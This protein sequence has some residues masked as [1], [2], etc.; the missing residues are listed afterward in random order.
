M[1]TPAY[2][3]HETAQKCLQYPRASNPFFKPNHGP[4]GLLKA[5]A[6]FTQSFNRI[7]STKN[8]GN[9]TQLKFMYSKSIKL[10]T[11]LRF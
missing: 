6:A 11:F 3:S 1:V 9:L 2:L 8:A 10:S 5:I 4:S 7:R